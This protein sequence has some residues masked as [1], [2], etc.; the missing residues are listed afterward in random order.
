[1]PINRGETSPSPSSMS[2]RK[3]NNY[4]RAAGVVL[5]GQLLFPETVGRREPSH[6]Q[7]KKFFRREATDDE[8]KKERRSFMNFLFSTNTTLWTQLKD[9]SIEKIAEKGYIKIDKGHIIA[10]DFENQG[11]GGEIPA[12]IGDFPYLQILN[13][14]NCN[15]TGPIP[16]EI[17]KLQRLVIA[18]LSHNQL[19]GGIPEG[20]SCM[21]DLILLD[22][23]HNSLTG[24]IPT[25]LTRLPKLFDFYL[26]NN[27]FSGE[28]PEFLGNLVSL[29]ELNL[30]HNQF[31]GTV[32]RSFKSF[33]RL[34]F[35]WLNDNNLSGEIHQD[36]LAW[37]TT[38]KHW[39]L[40]NNKGL[41]LPPELR[42]NVSTNY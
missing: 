10:L 23:S 3:L 6:R 12:E 29:H 37:L 11:L 41:K 27:N 24:T 5:A 1:M 21:R 2:R 22:F 31:T 28:I 30:S 20:M 32:P 18:R 38:V 33:N 8:M 4:L 36:V 26:N 19:T 13:L 17:T 16:P 7:D 40:D 39:N 9:L 34:C 15:F 25:D 35:L 42:E 14:S